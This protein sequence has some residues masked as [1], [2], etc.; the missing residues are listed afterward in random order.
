MTL[1]FFLANGKLFIIGNLRNKIFYQK[2]KDDTYSFF[3]ILDGKK[4]SF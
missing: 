4:Q 3:V 2:G 1:S